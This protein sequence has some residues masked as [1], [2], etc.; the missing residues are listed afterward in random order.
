MFL[1]LW[2]TF[3]FRVAI[4]AQ[5]ATRFKLLTAQVMWKVSDVKSEI[6][7]TRML[8]QARPN[9]ATLHTSLAGSLV[10][11]VE[12][13]QDL[14]A[15]EMVEL[16]KLFE[17]SGL[18]QP[19]E[20]KIKSILD[21]K[22]QAKGT[23]SISKVQLQ[24]QQC[25]SLG[26]YFT[27]EELQALKTKTCWEGAAVIASRLRL[28]G[29]RSMKESTKKTATGLLIWFE[30][31]RGGSRPSHDAAYALSQ[32]MLQSFQSSPTQTPPGS[33]SLPVYPSEP[34]RL[35]PEHLQAAYGKDSPC[36]QDYP[37]LANLL[38]HHVPVRSTSAKVTASSKEPAKAIQVQAPAS[39]NSVTS[40]ADGQNMAN[41][42][43]MNLWQSF[44]QKSQEVL[45]KPEIQLLQPKVV[46]HPSATAN[47][48]ACESKP[49]DVEAICDQP[50]GTGAFG[51]PE[52][53]GPVDKDEV[54]NPKA[55]KSL[56]E[57]E[58]AAFALLQKR[59][60]KKRATGAAKLAPRDQQLL[61][62]LQAR[63]SQ[64]RTVH[65]PKH[66]LL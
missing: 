61:E 5:V 31:K 46:A 51:L 66:H 10:H 40:Q 6:E 16:Y 26:S 22:V 47:I 9:A 44:L 35:S 20:E 37:D 65:R 25:D 57:Y 1:A 30:I 27:S 42:F 34:G 49:A 36:P 2:F 50:Q 45:A 32:H 38:L 59:E 29:M 56:E 19:L 21:G 15:L 55:S 58:K 41:M 60:E 48:A 8:L 3:F 62:L 13:L 11:K 17:H 39:S 52:A 23:S 64:P 7:S 14:S 53:P 12:S 24:P 33:Q 28:L 54:D 63:R 4:L 43:C 18:P